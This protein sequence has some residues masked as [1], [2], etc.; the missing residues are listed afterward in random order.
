MLNGLLVVKGVVALS[1]FIL[2]TIAFL[3]MMQMR[4][5]IPAILPGT[6]AQ[7]RRWHVV[8]GRVSFLLFVFLAFLGTGLALYLYPPSSVRPW[9][10]VIVSVAATVVFV[11]KIVVVRRKVQP[12]MRQLLLVGI[13]L[14]LL[15]V[16]IFLTATVWAYWFKF[17]GV[18]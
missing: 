12:W 5:K 15:H 2:A 13:I 18:L 11:G 14:F 16:A 4:R 10:H 6:T 17:T 8:S 1:T 7:L 3:T 9:L